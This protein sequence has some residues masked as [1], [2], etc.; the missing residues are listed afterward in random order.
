M[1]NKIETVER[2]LSSI[3]Q[4]IYR[5]AITICIFTASG[6]DRSQYRTKLIAFVLKLNFTFDRICKLR[7][8]LIII[9]GTAFRASAIVRNDEWIVIKLNSP[10]RRTATMQWRENLNKINTSKISSSY[11]W[12][13]HQQQP[14]RRAFFALNSRSNTCSVFRVAKLSKLDNLI[15]LNGLGN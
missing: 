5:Y 14:S 11:T 12:A 4:Y 8:Q 9:I 6:Y 7:T 15:F 13:N 10:L 1:N 3:I 2:R